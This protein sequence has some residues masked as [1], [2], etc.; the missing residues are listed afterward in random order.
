MNNLV[1]KGTLLGLGI[2]LCSAGTEKLLAG[3]LKVGLILISCGLGFI[4][5]R[6]ATKKWFN[7]EL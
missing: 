7:E 2:I 3:D 4:A 1:S 5:I 6:E